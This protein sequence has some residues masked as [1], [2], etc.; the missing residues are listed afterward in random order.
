V[1]SMV[2]GI[3]EASD[4]FKYVQSGRIQ[5]Y[6]AVVAAGV[7]MLAAVFIWALFLQ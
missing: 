1:D 2:E 3:G 6:L 7:L 4:S 5:Q